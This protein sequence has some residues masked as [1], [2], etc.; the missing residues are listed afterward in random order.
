MDHVILWPWDV[1]L[2]D[3]RSVIR[4]E[5]HE[6]IGEDVVL[7]FLMGSTSNVDRFPILL[8]CAK[9]RGSIELLKMLDGS[10]TTT[11]VF[12]ALEEAQINNANAQEQELRDQVLF[13]CRLKFFVSQVFLLIRKQ[14][15]TERPWY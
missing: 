1:T 5:I 8:I 4:N 13:Y 11:E 15:N 7:P 2:P 12:A 14:E 10:K 3:A 9:I 6:L